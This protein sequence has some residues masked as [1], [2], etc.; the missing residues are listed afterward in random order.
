MDRLDL[1]RIVS[2]VKEL[3]KT[4]MRQFLPLFDTSLVIVMNSAEQLKNDLGFKSIEC[5]SQ[6]PRP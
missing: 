3:D 5:R 4:R 2:M 1:R 6:C